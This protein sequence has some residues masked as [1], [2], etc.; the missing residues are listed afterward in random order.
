MVQRSLVSKC[1]LN[2]YRTKALAANTVL[3]EIF[4]A[5]KSL[6]PAE[7]FLVDEATGRSDKLRQRGT[8]SDAVTG[9]HL[10]AGGR[11]LLTILLQAAEDSQ[12]ITIHD[13]LAKAGDIAR[14]GFLLLGSSAVRLLRECNGDI[15]CESRTKAQSYYEALQHSSPST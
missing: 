4:A 10:G 12:V 13:R 14:A 11:E 8:E 1:A 2:A 5:T 6:G 9:Q 15:E 3:H 7:G